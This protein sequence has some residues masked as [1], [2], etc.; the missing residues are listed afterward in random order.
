MA[1]WT[2]LIAPEFDP[3]LRTLAAEIRMELLAQARVIE[4][5]GPTASRPRVDTLRGSRYANMKELRFDAAGGVWRVAFSFDPKRM[6]VL[7]VA[8]DKSGQSEKE[9]LQA[10][11]PAG[12]SAIRGTSRPPRSAWMSRRRQMARTLGEFVASLP[13]RERRKIEA[14]SKQLI[15]EEMSLRELRKAIGK[16]QTAVARKL[17]IGQ[18]AVS[19]LEARGDMYLSTL[20]SMLE[21]MGG[22]LELVARFPGRPATKLTVHETKPRSRRSDRKLAA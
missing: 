10:I 11:D 16:T 5:F 8:G 17:G 22:E 15:A 4:R 14:R 1:T 6:A 19:K 7:L 12:R 2:V 21:A 3:E 18:E 13:K 9:V 20:R